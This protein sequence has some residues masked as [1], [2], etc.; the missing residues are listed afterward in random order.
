M[1]AYA[2]H[3]LKTKFL[4]MRCPKGGD[5]RTFLTNLHFKRQELAAAG[6]KLDDQDYQWMVLCGIPGELVMFTAALLSAH[7]MP[8]PASP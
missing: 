2:H 1:S 8:L 3:N 7:A 6:V 5:V 4:E